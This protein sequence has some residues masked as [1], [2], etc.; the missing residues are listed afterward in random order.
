MGWT[1]S[2]WTR[3]ELIELLTEPGE[4]DTANY[5]TIAYALRGNVLWQVVR[6]SSKQPAV[7]E[8]VAGYSSTVIRCVLLERTSGW[9]G[10]R[11]MTEQDEPEYYSCPLRYL[12]LA[13]ELCSEWREGVREYHAGL[14]A[15]AP[16][17]R[18]F[19]TTQQAAY[20]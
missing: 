2:N 4:T 14:R 16:R 15:S 19:P 18:A 13:P 6:H 1:F 3:S 17:G 5:E 7:L 9:W 8:L 12:A 10:Y 11:I 20:A